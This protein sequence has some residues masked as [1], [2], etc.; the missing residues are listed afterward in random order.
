MSV[1]HVS[2]LFFP[3]LSGG[4]IRNSSLSSTASVSV[5]S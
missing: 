5:R 2:F 1:F 3:S 4:L